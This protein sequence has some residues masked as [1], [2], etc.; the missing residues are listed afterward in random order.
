MFWCLSLFLIPP[1]WQVGGTLVAAAKHGWFLSVPMCVCVCVLNG[2]VGGQ[3]YV[4][5]PAGEQAVAGSNW[6]SAERLSN[7]R[8]R[9]DSSHCCHSTEGWR[10]PGRLEG[11]WDYQLQL[12][13]MLAP[14]L[15]S[16][17]EVGGSAEWPMC[18]KFL[19]IFYSPAVDFD[20]GKLSWL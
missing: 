16:T 10:S 6:G 1:R 7:N 11:L 12:L 19:H 15:P 8:K 9:S 5:W 13:W 20:D 3:P 17:S 14:S 2:G 4:T 18:H